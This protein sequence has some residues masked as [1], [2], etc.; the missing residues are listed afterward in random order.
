MFV[1]IAY[2]IMSSV[3]MILVD[4]N[5]KYFV[6]T[7]TVICFLHTVICQYVFTLLARNNFSELCSRH[8]VSL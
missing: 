8:M 2:E 1:S 7:S 4:R 6:Q 3:I 5:V